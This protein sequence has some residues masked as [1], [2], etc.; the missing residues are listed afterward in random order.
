MPSGSILVC[1]LPLTERTDSN[2]A[3][4]VPSSSA[5]ATA[6]FFLLTFGGVDRN[7]EEVSVRS[8]CKLESRLLSVT[9]EWWPSKRRPKLPHIFTQTQLSRDYEEAHGVY[10]FVR[11]PNESRKQWKSASTPK[12]ELLIRSHAGF[13]SLFRT[14]YV[15]LFVAVTSFLT[16]HHMDSSRRAEQ[17]NDEYEGRTIN[18]HT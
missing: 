1:R 10:S 7:V 16:C 15:H 11:L 14:R 18:E 4:S 6:T 8:E 5:S 3:L 17:R 9:F 2:T 12:P 13:F